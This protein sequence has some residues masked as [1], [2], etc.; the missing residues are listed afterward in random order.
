MRIVYFSLNPSIFAITQ[1]T[2]CLYQDD[3]IYYVRKFNRHI[4]LGLPVEPSD[5]SVV[6]WAPLSCGAENMI[7]A[8]VSSL[9][10]ETASKNTE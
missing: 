1:I 9:M 10:N 6:M 7:E 4:E 2:Q 8:K 3:Q 5:K